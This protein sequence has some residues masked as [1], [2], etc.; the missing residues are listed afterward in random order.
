[1]GTALNSRRTNR[2]LREKSSEN[3]TALFSVENMVEAGM[4]KKGEF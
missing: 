3:K 2:K 4:L 1:M